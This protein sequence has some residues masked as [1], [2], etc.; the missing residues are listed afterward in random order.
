MYIGIIVFWLLKH[1]DELD[2]KTPT[3]LGGAQ[4]FFWGQRPLCPL[5]GYDPAILFVSN[6]Q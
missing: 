5:A 1:S 3:L 4:H 2:I 6:L